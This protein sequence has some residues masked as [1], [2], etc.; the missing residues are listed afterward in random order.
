MTEP[1][2]QQDDTG[3]VIAAAAVGL[4]LIALESRVRQ[5]VEDDTQAAFS[6]I[7]AAGL[8]AAAAP[9]GTVLT[10]LALISLASFHTT[11]TGMLGAARR[12]VADDISAGYSAAA[13]L[14]LVRAR[15]DLAGY[16]YTVAGT[17]PELGSNID[18]ILSD[19]DTM[20]G[21]AQS[22]V[23]NRM[24]AAWDASTPGT[25]HTA[26]LDAADGSAARLQQRAQAAA[27]TAVH[28]GSSDAQQAIYNQFQNDTGTPGLMKRWR[29]TSTTP[30]GMCDALNGTLVGVNGEF[31]H[32]ATTVDKD[33]RRVWRNLLGP[34]R[35]PNCRCQIELV[36][37]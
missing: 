26:L 5:E 14:A 4:A 2:G 25:R 32:H 8:V 18:R 27:T 16:G 20:F 15:S 29:T 33:L 7:A 9:P 12:N 1:V 21:H 35:H 28:Q 31:D 34:P 19:V 11:L 37:T 36:R 6:G 17:L 13:Q 10:G 22:D 23:Q 24:A 30:C 3:T